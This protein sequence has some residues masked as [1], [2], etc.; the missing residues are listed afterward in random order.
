MLQIVQRLSSE[1]G[2]LKDSNETDAKGDLA[3]LDHQFTKLWDK[4][5]K[6]GWPDHNTTTGIERLYNIGGATWLMTAMVK[7][8][9]KE[10]PSERRQ[11]CVDGALAVAHLDLEACAIALATKVLPVLITRSS[12]LAR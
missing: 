4:I 11:R 12:T 8:I 6:H 7:A 9:I 5:L 3:S 1:D 2:P 10:Q